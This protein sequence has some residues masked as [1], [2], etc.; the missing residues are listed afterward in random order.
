MLIFFSWLKH[1]S[2]WSS[3]FP[4]PIFRSKYINSSHRNTAGHECENHAYRYQRVKNTKNA[5]NLYNNFVILPY[6]IGRRGGL[7]LSPHDESFPISY[8]SHNLC[9]TFGY[10]PPNLK[11]KWNTTSNFIFCGW[12]MESIILCH[13]EAKW[14]TWL[15]DLYEWRIRSMPWPGCGHEVYGWEWSFF[16]PDWEVIWN[17]E[18]WL[19]NT[20]RQA[21]QWAQITLKYF[22][23]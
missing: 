3:V 12:L 15:S 2:V 4:K 19:A 18:A 16:P 17:S 1:I 13:E 5:N 22:F 10:F 21:Q 20:R 7:L 9:I 11:R 8:C 14:L 6:A 23:L